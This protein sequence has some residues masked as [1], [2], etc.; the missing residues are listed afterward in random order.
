MTIK[1]LAFSVVLLSILCIL[2]GNA[3]NWVEQF[4]DELTKGWERISGVAE[5]RVRWEAVE[6]IL[7]TEIRRPELP[8][9]CEETDADFLHWTAHQFRLDSL[10]VIGSEIV[11]PP[12]GRNTW[13]QLALFLG[14]RQTSPDFV[15]K[16]Y[17]FSPEMATEVTFRENEGYTKGKTISVYDKQFKL[18]TKNLKVTFDS[19]KFRVLSGTMLLSDFN[20][21]TIPE[22]DV[23]G[24]LTICHNEGD[25]FGG[26]ISSF[27]ISGSGI[28]NHNQS[29]DVQ[30]RDTQ[31]STT[32]ARL[33]EFE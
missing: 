28:P 2:N 3:G 32:W 25:W 26:S 5:W 9:S 29:L 6:G 8:G 17:Y 16:G 19:G 1:K 12:P 23:V 15:A 18:T 4:D 20:D 24:L 7:F 14:K 13:G 22:I 21:V 33:K 31:L 10:T 27:S 30:L 11:Y